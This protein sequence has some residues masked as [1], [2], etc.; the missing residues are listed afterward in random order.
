MAR[1]FTDLDR[2][3]IIKHA[4]EWC[5]QHGAPKALPHSYY[6][7]S[8]LDQADRYADHYLALLVDSDDPSYWPDHSKVYWPW[9]AEDK[10]VTA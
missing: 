8:I 3:Y 7:E 2:K 4:R 9:Q 10:L 1:V 6:S 5:I